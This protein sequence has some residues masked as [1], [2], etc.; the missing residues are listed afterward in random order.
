M[1][2]DS[3]SVLRWKKF[4]QVLSYVSCTQVRRHVHKQTTKRRYGKEKPGRFLFGKPILFTLSLRLTT[5]Y[6]MGILVWNFYQTFFTVYVEF[7]AE[8]RAIDSSH[9][10]DN[11]YLIHHCQGW[12]ED[13]FVCETV[14]FF[15]LVNTHSFHLKFVMFCHKFNGDSYVEFQEKTISGDFF[16][17]FMQ[18]KAIIYQNL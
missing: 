14:W 11:K 13:S 15:S 9:K 4:T 8:I 12:K 3:R 16:I 6:S 2:F 1:Q 17:N 18:T 7:L 10:I 5:P